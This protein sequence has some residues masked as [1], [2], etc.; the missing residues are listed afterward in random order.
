MTVS[1]PNWLST[2]QEYSP[3]SSR[4]T[5]AIC[6]EPSGNWRTRSDGTRGWPF[7]W[8]DD[9]KP[10]CKGRK[11]VPYKYNMVYGT[12]HTT[13]SVYGRQADKDKTTENIRPH[14]SYRESGASETWLSSPVFLTR[15]CD[16][17]GQYRIINTL[18]RGSH[19]CVC[20]LLL[21]LEAGVD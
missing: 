21:V 20:D 14:L 19:Y 4:A 17:C 13:S 7:T 2:W 9:L 18:V 3:A 1:V 12:L 11:V 6:R 10:Y 5:P 15:S 16:V 8:T